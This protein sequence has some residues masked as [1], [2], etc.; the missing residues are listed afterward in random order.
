MN[1]KLDNLREIAEKI[2][3]EYRYY[4][5]TSLT[6]GLPGGGKSAFS[7]AVNC[8]D[9]ICPGS[10]ER[11]RK[12]KALMRPT[13][14]DN[15]TETYVH[16]IREMH[17]ILKEEIMAFLNCTEHEANLWIDKNIDFNH[18]HL[19]EKESHK[20]MQVDPIFKEK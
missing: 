13:E 12:M 8:S 3:S 1:S 9:E 16:T 2:T 18:V 6:G 11:V 15:F 4:D 14:Y 19:S 10:H 5:N 20:Y 7:H 17:K